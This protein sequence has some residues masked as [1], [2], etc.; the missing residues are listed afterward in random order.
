MKKILSVILLL[1][2]FLT[3]CTK[4]PSDNGDDLIVRHG[5]ENV[6]NLGMDSVDTLNPVLSKSASVRECMEL[7][8]EPFFSFDDSFNPISVLAEDCVMNDAYSY[9]LNLKSGIMWHDG[10]EMTA[11]DAEHTFNLI[12][13]NDTPYTSQI[14]PVSG[15]RYI[16]KYTLGITLSRPV[17]NIKALLSFPVVQTG[18]SASD[19]NYIPVGTGPYKYN[20]KISSNKFSLVP[21]ENWRGTLATIDKVY[22]HSVRDKQALINAYNASTVS[23][24]SSNIMDLRNNTP[25]GENNINDFVSDSFVFLGINNSRSEFSQEGTRRA[26]SYLI[27]KNDIVTTE[28]FSRAVSVDL[29]INPSAWYCPKNNSDKPGREEIM[30]LLLSDGWQQNQNKKFTRKVITEDGGEITESLSVNICVNSDNEEKIRIAKK[31]ANSLSQFGIEAAVSPVDFEGYKRAIEEKT[32]SMFI[33][34]VK[35]GYNMD[36]YS[37][38]ADSLNYFSSNSEAMKTAVYNL[39][40]KANDEEIKNAFSEFS[41][42]FSKEMPF[43]PLFFRKESVIFEKNISGISMPTMFCAFRNPENWYISKTKTAE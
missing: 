3:A 13:Y 18:T 38:T 27:D 17:P 31:I 26:I 1:S 41:S 29:P 39:G 20:E 9:T 23:V 33:G 30:Q 5:T 6:L 28:V 35:M 11:A 21:N 42:V 32:Y 4:S 24:V 10:T 43:V 7:V 25:R 14:A 34:E 16:D 8:F 40:T 15:V 36:P 37:L 19:E 22:I 2:L 12:R